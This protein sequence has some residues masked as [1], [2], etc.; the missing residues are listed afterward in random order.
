V[1]AEIGLEEVD[2]LEMEVIKRQVSS[3]WALDPFGRCRQN[4]GVL[5]WVAVRAVSELTQASLSPCDGVASCR[6]L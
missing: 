4:H 2:G 3:F 6:E 5:G 1:A